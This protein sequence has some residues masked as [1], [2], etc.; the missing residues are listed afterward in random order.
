MIVTL[1]DLN[2]FL[3]MRGQENWV[4][5]VSSW[6]YLTIWRPVCQFFPKHREPHFCSP[7]GVPSRGCWNPAAAA[8][9]D[10]VPAEVD[11][12]GRT[13]VDQRNCQ[14]GCLTSRSPK[15]L[16]SWDQELAQPHLWCCGEML[17]WHLCATN[18]LSSSAP[19][20]G[21]SG[22]DPDIWLRFL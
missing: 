13:A 20:W 16:P 9:H 18:P 3:D 11:G 19:V 1:K 14:P 6:K 12:K 7:P 10:S 2:A 21:H 17:A 22:E 8:A 15:S 5:K 4:H